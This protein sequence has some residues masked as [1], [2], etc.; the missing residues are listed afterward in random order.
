MLAS[1]SSVLGFSSAPSS[2]GPDNSRFHHYRSQPSRWRPPPNWGIS[3]SSSLS[4][5]L[6]WAPA[7]VTVHDSHRAVPRPSL[8]CRI[9]AAD[10]GFGGTSPDPI[11]CPS[12]NDRES[13]ESSRSTSCHS[14]SL[15]DAPMAESSS[16]TDAG[17]LPGVMSHQSGS[18]TSGAPPGLRGKKHRSGSL[19]S[20]SAAASISLPASKPSPR[21]R[22]RT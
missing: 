9:R 19:N 1:S 21:A 8:R 14:S 22:Q 3:Q 20:L 7:A 16:A 17:V 2:L 6:A 11:G 13:V 10:G 18:D 5:A 12:V 15:Y 4:Q